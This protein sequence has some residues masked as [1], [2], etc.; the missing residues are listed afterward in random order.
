MGTNKETT[1]KIALSPEIVGLLDALREK[2]IALAKMSSSGSTLANEALARIGERT[3]DLARL[4]IQERDDNLPAVGKIQKLLQEIALKQPN[5]QGEIIQLTD[6]QVIAIGKY[7]DS[8]DQEPSDSR[9]T[10]NTHEKRELRLDLGNKRIITI[11]AHL[12]DPKVLT[13]ELNRQKT[14]EE[15]R[16][17]AK[18]LDRLFENRSTEIVLDKN[19]SETFLRVFEIREPSHKGNKYDITTPRAFA[20]IVLADGRKISVMFSTKRDNNKYI[21]NWQRE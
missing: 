9:T 2:I 12:S 15:K 16:E 17:L 10:D 3:N 11:I 4:A 8:V 21:A 5:T 1:D 18:W 6:E 20:I 14:E 19:D 7:V 13:W